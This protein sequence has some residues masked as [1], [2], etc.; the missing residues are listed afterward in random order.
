MSNN[1]EKKQVATIWILT[2]L[3]IILI[4]MVAG[5]IIKAMAIKKQSNTDAEQKLAQ[6]QQELEQVKTQTIKNENIE[7]KNVQNNEQQEVED[8]DYNKSFEERTKAFFEKKEELKDNR[9]KKDFANVRLN[10]IDNHYEIV[11]DIIGN[12]K[13]ESDTL[14]NAI[15]E[16]QDNKLD[17]LEIET[18]NNKTVI[19]Y[20]SRPEETKYTPK[21]IEDEYLK[22]HV[23][24]LGYVHIP[25]YDDDDWFKATSDNEWLDEKGIPMY[26]DASSIG[27][28]ADKWAAL[29][30][31]DDGYYIYS[32][33][34]AGR[35][36]PFSMLDTTEIDAVRIILASQE[37][38]V[39][40]INDFYGSLPEDYQF[41]EVTVD[42]YFKMSPI[43]LKDNLR[44]NAS[45]MSEAN[46][47]N[48]GLEVR[49]GK[50]Y[51]IA[52]NDGP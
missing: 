26:V 31:D 51:V 3:I 48:I 18:S 24:S 32:R 28:E 11:A 19:I 35:T 16:I 46:Y 23:N 49:D 39:L 17:K 27:G 52:R 1:N 13:I 22:K 30:K 29:K 38:I 34:G 15:K 12:V 2:I 14:K 47:Y 43:T 10:K 44:I 21:D 45:N 5:L 36:V 7:E 8:K 9:Q 41:K 4:A 42:E 37:K 25:V 40:S 50:I 6:T 33:H 20:S